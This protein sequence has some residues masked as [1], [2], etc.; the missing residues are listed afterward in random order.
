ML[1][2]NRRGPE[3]LD[4][5]GG[6]LPHSSPVFL[7]C[8]QKRIRDFQKGG[9]AYFPP[10]PRS[11]ER[12][13]HRKFVFDLKTFL[14]FHSQI[15]HSKQSAQSAGQIHGGSCYA[16][17]RPNPTFCCYSV[18]GIHRLFPP[19]IEMVSHFSDILTLNK[20][21]ISNLKLFA[22]YCKITR[23]SLIP[24]KPLFSHSQSHGNRIPFCV[25]GPA[26]GGAVGRVH[27]RV[28]PPGLRPCNRPRILRSLRVCPPPGPWALSLLPP[29]SRLGQKL[30][31]L[32]PPGLALVSSFF[33][34]W[35]VLYYPDLVCLMR[36]FFPQKERICHFHLFIFRK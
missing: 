32:E 17:R 22:N 4:L 1:P 7:P 25:A 30:T 5:E 27:G 24:P 35:S 19:S 14:G 18:C 10:R 23:C 36:H 28:H 33:L 20:I 34:R 16:H 31:I 11:S 12:D 21:T 13:I 29:P 6:T 26:R 8:R 2:R 9:G 15:N 3:H